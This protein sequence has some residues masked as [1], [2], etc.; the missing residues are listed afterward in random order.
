MSMK[1][2]LQ[3]LTEV[4]TLRQNAEF[5][6]E[7]VSDTFQKKTKVFKDSGSSDDCSDEMSSDKSD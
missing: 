6:G 4:M 7:D 1:I 2:L 5:T 3:V